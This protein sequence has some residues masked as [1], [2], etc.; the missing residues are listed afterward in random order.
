MSLRYKIKKQVVRYKQRSAK[1]AQLLALNAMS[2]EQ[3]KTYNMVK[4]LAIKHR[5]CIKFDP[6]SLEILIVLPKMLITLKSDTVYIHNTNGF[7]TVSLRTD[8][9]EMLVKIIQI[10]AHRERRKLKYEV[11]LRIN[12]FINKITESNNLETKNT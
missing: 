3:T 6:Y 7:L 11:K 8:V 2:I 4:D 9:Y 12:D 10:E 5:D 1:K